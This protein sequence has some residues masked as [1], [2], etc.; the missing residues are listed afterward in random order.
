[1]CSGSHTLLWP[2][3]MS[4]YQWSRPRVIDTSPPVRRTTTTLPID[5]HCCSASSLLRFSGTLPPRRQPSSAVIST[6]ASASFM[7]SRTASALNPPNTTECGAP[8]R[9]QASIATGSS[10]IMGR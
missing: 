3:M 2:W 5:G 9:A 1:M 6:V 10:G 4:W 8:M 7:R